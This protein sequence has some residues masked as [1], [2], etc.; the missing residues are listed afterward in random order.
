VLA[1]DD[2]L[3]VGGVWAA[4]MVILAVEWALRTPVLG[5][6]ALPTSLHV[7]VVVAFLGSVGAALFV[8]SL[9]GYRALAKRSQERRARSRR[10]ITS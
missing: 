3:V 9:R 2:E 6:A 8:G 1:W 7:V 4:A 5:A 10:R